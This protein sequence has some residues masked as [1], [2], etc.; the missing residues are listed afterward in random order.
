MSNLTSPKAP[1]SVIVAQ[2]PGA[3]G[4]RL[5]GN[6]GGALYRH[7][8]LFCPL[9]NRR[10]IGVVFEDNGGTGLGN[11]EA[12]RIR[13]VSIIQGLGYSLSQ[14]AFVKLPIQP[15]LSR[16][17]FGSGG[18]LFNVKLGSSLSLIF[19]FLTKKLA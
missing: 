5:S 19:F 7:G 13:D 4:V 17:D 12:N 10:R 14:T 16:V 1:R 15:D 9:Q 2:L 11:P 3:L 8:N 18:S 6:G